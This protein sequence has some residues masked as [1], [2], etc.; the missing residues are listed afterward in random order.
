MKYV[1]VD[2]DGTIADCTERARKYLGVQK[3]WDSFY[4][5]C[6]DDFVIEPIAEL[7]R[8]LS[9]KWRIVYCSGRREECREATLR[10]LR[11]H[12]L[13]F[14]DVLLLRPN[15]NTTHDTDIKPKLLNSF[16][17]KDD[18]AF[19]IEDRDSMVSLWRAMGYTVLQPAPGNF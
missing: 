10:W 3:D 13:D 18:V 11:R 16:C 7:V 5:H 15:R 9:E 17:T 12:H 19:I 1:I 14:H 6:E 4:A 8:H 2:I